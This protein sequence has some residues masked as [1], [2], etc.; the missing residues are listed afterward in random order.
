M[1]VFN[2]RPPVCWRI[3]ILSLVSLTS[4]KRWLIHILAMEKKRLLRLLEY[5]TFFKTNSSMK[6][7][8]VG[9][10]L[11]FLD[12]GRPYSNLISQILYQPHSNILFLQSSFPK[13]SMLAPGHYFPSFTFPSMP[14]RISRQFP[15]HLI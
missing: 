4:F 10:C 11:V 9:N 6:R 1:L 12:L 14:T 15:R 8:L 13:P 2:R 7:L 3:R 5:S